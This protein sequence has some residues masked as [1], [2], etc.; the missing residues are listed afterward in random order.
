MARQ[1]VVPP[2]SGIPCTQ[3]QCGYAM[4]TVLSPPTSQE[5]GDV[6]LS[7]LSSLGIPCE[8]ERVVSGPQVTRY[9]LR[10]GEGVLMREILRT[11]DDL[12]FATGA[13][14]ARIL[15][16]LP[17]R[18]DLIGVELPCAE[19]RIVRLSELPPPIQP[20]SFPLGLDVDGEPLYCDLAAC[21]HLLVAGETGS[22]KSS[23]I[24]AMLCSLLS[25]FGPDQLALVLIDPKQVELTPYEG[26][27]HLLAPI[28]DDVDSALARLSSL[29]AMM[30]LRYDV[31]AKLGA[32]SLPE[33]NAKLEAA[34]YQRYPSVVA[35][36]D[37]TADLMMSSR[38]V[39]ESLIVRIA[40]KA[41]AVGIHLVLATQSPRVAVVTGLIKANVPSRICFSVSSQTDSRVVLDR[42]GAETL[43]GQGDGLLSLGGARPLRFQG[44]FV[45][46][47][48]IQT[49]CGQWR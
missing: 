12:S 30:E 19:R 3:P 38:R 4:S 49:V 31:A 44:A 25:R 26:I 2:Q 7:K 29:V 8:L 18:A 34:G 10:P 32:R 33:I 11:A 41:R 40:Q 22:G 17:G 28:A 24:N 35:V 47:N 5:R 14:P 39:S 13:Y 48:E 1:D 45:D 42:N 21:P 15:A 6:L 9:E 37:E 27:D 20:L 23:M 46:S 16:P 36:V 43:L